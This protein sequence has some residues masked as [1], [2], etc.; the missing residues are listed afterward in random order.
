MKA[1]PKE[2]DSITDHSE[3]TSKNY[4]FQ[5]ATIANFL[6]NVHLFLYCVYRECMYLTKRDKIL[7]LI[8]EAYESFTL[9]FQGKQVAQHLSFTRLALSN[10]MGPQNNS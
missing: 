3:N 8:V 1:V 7:T 9:C 6:Y 4:T 10:Y 5:K 2:N